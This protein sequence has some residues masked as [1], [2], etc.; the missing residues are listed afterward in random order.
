MYA[1]Y[2]AIIKHKLRTAKGM[3][4]HHG[5]TFIGL[6]MVAY[7]IFYQLYIVVMSGGIG[8]SL[9]DKYVFYCLL[10]CVSLNGYRVALKQTPII[11]MN[12]ATLYYI[13]LTKYFRQI[14]TVKY[15]WSLIKNI[16]IA[17]VISGLFNGFQGDFILGR[18]FFLL[19]GYLFLGI[20]L[21]WSRYHSTNKKMQLTAT[22]SYIITSAV[23]LMEGGII[24]IIINYCFMVFWVYYVVFKLRFNL[25]RYSKDLAFADNLT[26]ASSQFDMGKMT[27]IAVENVAN[28][29]RRFFLHQLPIKKS[30][31]IFYKS[32]IEMVRGGNH[33]WILFLCLIFAGFLIY[34]TS[35]FAG[36]PILGESAL[37]V[38]L[39]ILAV[40]NVYLKIKEMLKKQVS[41]LLKKHRQGLFL[42]MEKREIVWSYII[43]S[44]LIYA[45]LTI[46]VGLLLGSKAYL[47]LLFYVLFVS[48]F[49]V[50]FAIETAHIKFKKPFQIAIQV[51]S[52]ALGRIF[53]I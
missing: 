51:L 44:S 53:I 3:L 31:V 1:V 10:V 45:I 36:I 41:A 21:S 48:T 26:S 30:N 32:L 38:P 5:L 14:L 43:F 50:D 7:V 25:I 49:T 2:S 24:S 42:P 22:I 35:V 17:V 19:T 52:F 33:L 15:L 13:Y 40:M 27:Q 39:C 28:K 12:A 4:R 8:I 47:L 18:Y 37:S 46:L 9:S 20:L 16:M 34:R 6:L 23:L 29:K 11:T